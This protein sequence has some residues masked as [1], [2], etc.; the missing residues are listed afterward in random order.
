MSV[1]LKSATGLAMGSLL[2]YS[3][4]K[5]FSI[6][7]AVQN[8][9]QH[10][11]PSAGQDASRLALVN[12][13][14]SGGSNNPGQVVSNVGSVQQILKKTAARFGWDTGQ[15]WTSLVAIENAEAGFNPKIKNPTSGALGLAQ[16]LGHGTANTAGTLGNQYGGFGLSDAQAKRANSGSAP[17]QAAWMVDYIKSTY[18][19]PIKAWAFHQANGWY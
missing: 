19:D 16:A 7:K 17:E 2:I 9:I 10:Q 5:G 15:E 8:I 6:L 12:I 1:N 18:G 4:I 14:D 3:G 11:K 13:Q